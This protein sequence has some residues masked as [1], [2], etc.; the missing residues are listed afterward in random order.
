[1]HKYSFLDK[2]KKFFFLIVFFKNHKKLVIFSG[3]CKKYFSSGEKLDW[4]YETGVKIFF[5]WKIVFLVKYKKF[6]GWARWL[7]QNFWLERHEQFLDIS[8]SWWKCKKY[9]EISVLWQKNFLQIF[10]LEWLRKIFKLV[11]YENVTHF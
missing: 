4:L 11:H 7:S 6:L 9:L 10:F 5:V 2:H 1:M 8:F 3:K